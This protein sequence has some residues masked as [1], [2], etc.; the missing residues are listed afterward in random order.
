MPEAGQLIPEDAARS[1]FQDDPLAK[2]MMAHIDARFYGAT[3]LKRGVGKRTALAHYVKYGHDQGY[4]PN[5]R[6]DTS[7]YRFL[8]WDT[9][10]LN[11]LKHWVG[12]GQQQR[13]LTF[14]LRRPELIEADGVIDLRGHAVVSERFV[15]TDDYLSCIIVPIGN[16]NNQ[17][18]SGIFVCVRMMADED[19]ETS[20]DV[21]IAK[22]TFDGRL[23]SQHEPFT[24]YFD[25]V[26]HS[27]GRLFEISLKSIVPD[28]HSAA[29]PIYVRRSTRPGAVNGI[30]NSFRY[31]LLIEEKYSPPDSPVTIPKK[32]LYSPTTQCNL[33]CIHCVSAHTRKSVHRAGDDIKSSIREWAAQG[34]IS[35]LISDY[36]GDLLWADHRIPGELDFVI[37]LDVPF[38]VS[39]NGVHLDEE[40]ATKL[41][42]SRMVS[43]NI[44][45][46]AA[47][48]ATFKRVRKGAPDLDVVISNIRQF[49]ELK[50]IVTPLWPGLV[51]LSFA[52]MKSNLHELVAFVKL[53]DRLG[54]RAI[55]TEQVQCYT[56]D[57]VSES[58]WFDKERFNTVREQAF[59]VAVEK[60]I[61]LNISDPFSSRPPHNGRRY[62]P[63]P[64]YA[65]VLL[66]N[67]D[68]QACCVP[69]SK[70]G[71]INDESLESLWAGEKL[72][73][74]R[75]AVNSP[76]PPKAC[77][78][79]PLLATENNA[80]A[81]TPCRPNAPGTFMK[82][83]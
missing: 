68:V 61:T 31:G 69:G 20:E 53:A 4:W 55:V 49:V 74:F 81:Y 39:T 7:F 73:E 59:A 26:P 83:L 29:W 30:R 2:E 36:S 62:C 14:G 37:G 27:K 15:A 21:V 58:L 5:P 41:L 70:L 50:D 67:G 44:S 42:K 10:S 19:D 82:P 32:L 11:A 64:W 43:L 60:G 18:D 34:K 79:C 54:I 22:Y 38:Q 48:N 3:Y 78:S 77:L 63:E 80:G 6:F 13:R 17:N 1:C 46:D 25:P 56:D 72:R 51:T 57:M 47:T 23:P 76:S 66:A 12:W 33:N 75:L 65:A 40:R 8:A 16:Y 35:L 9:R 28:D 24:I 45:L 71:N 52:L